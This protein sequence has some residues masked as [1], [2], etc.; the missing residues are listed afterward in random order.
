MDARQIMPQQNCD[1]LADKPSETCL[2]R[3][4]NPQANAVRVELD[5]GEILRTQANDLRNWVA[6]VLGDS[7]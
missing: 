3:P 2:D 1:N 7:D 4:N 6:F 5:V